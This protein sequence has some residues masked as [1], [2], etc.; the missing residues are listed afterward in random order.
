LRFDTSGGS[1]TAVGYT[2]LGANA[3]AHHSTAVGY[4][5]LGSN[6]GGQNTAMGSRAMLANNIGTYNSVLG[7]TSLGT[8]T[9]GNYNVAFGSMAGYYI[10]DGASGNTTGDYNVFIG[11]DSRAKTN[12]DQNQIVIGYGAI[13]NGSDTATIG[14]DSILKTILKGSIGIGTTTPAAKLEVVS[15]SGNTSI[16]AGLKRISNVDLPFDI[17]DA[18]TKGYVDSTVN[19][20][21]SSLT[22]I[23]TFSAS[24]AATYTGAQSG[25]TGGNALCNAA[26]AGSHV[27]TTEEILY[28]VNSGQGAAIPFNS[29]LWISNGP[30]AYTAN[31]ND[32]QGW[33][34]AAAADY[35]TVWIKLATGDGFGG[36][37]RCNSTYKF[38]CCK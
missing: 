29:T 21:T 23:A 32:C 19:A 7:Y 30:P 18:A 36:L 9:T 22:A 12:N 1:N 3:T 16:L 34:S 17:T 11:A 15:A 24:T 31:A 5:T 14:N 8:N 6:V 4:A 28:T 2:A 20:A 33:T 37:N 25:Y 10:E 27:C 26:S 35:G 13:G 38:A